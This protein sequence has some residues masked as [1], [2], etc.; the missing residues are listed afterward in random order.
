MSVAHLEQQLHEHFAYFPSLV[1]IHRPE[2]PYPLHVYAD[3]LNP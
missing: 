1:D 2:Y 3:V